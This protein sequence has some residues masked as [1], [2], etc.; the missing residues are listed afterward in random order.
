ML[1]GDTGVSGRITQINN[2]LD[3]LEAGNPLFP[4][5][6]DAASALEIVPVHDNMDKKIQCNWYP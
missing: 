4:P 1:L 5:D 2:E 6:S 3:N